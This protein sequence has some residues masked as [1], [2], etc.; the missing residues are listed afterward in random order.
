MKRTPEDSSF[1][2][3]C[4]KELRRHYDRATQT[5]VGGPELS[6]ERFAATL[7][8]TRPAL[9]KYLR[10]GAMPTL[11]V[12]VLAFVRYG[13]NLPYLGVP[14]F[15]TETQQAG[16]TLIAQLVLPFSVQGLNL[17]TILTKIEAKGENQFDLY[18][19]VQKAG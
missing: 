4:G 2:A 19:D 16:S 18:V 3:E 5:G 15:Q 14:L 6:D 12:V 7:N 1:A 9:K 17:A 11:R 13:I 8:V 10:G